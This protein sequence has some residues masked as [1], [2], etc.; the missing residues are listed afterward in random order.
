M[1]VKKPK[2]YCFARNLRPKFLINWFLINKKECMELISVE[3]GNKDQQENELLVLE[4]IY[5]DRQFVVA[6]QGGG[7]RLY[8]HVELAENF[9]I[10]YPAKYSSGRQVAI[11]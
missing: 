3:E 1:A 10:T 4:S 6:S 8:V 7:G 11:F 5:G 9:K 2:I